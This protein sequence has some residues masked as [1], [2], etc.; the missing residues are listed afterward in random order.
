MKRVF[1]MMSL[2]FFSVFCTLSTA[3]AEMVLGGSEKVGIGTASPQRLLH[4][5]G[6][7][8]RILIEDNWTSNPEINF[9][10]QSGAYGNDWAIYKHYNSGDLRFYNAG[11][12]VT[13]EYDSGWVGIGVDNPKATL[14]VNG[15]VLLKDISPYYEFFA[16]YSGI[17]SNAGQLYSVDG[18]GNTTQISP[19]DAE[20]G[21]W[22]F[23]SKNVK[24]GKVFRVNMEK[25]V[26]EVEKLTGKK[27]VE[28]WVEK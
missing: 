5:Y 10:T 11:D 12:K 24:T 18:A 19:H 13:F 15:T 22:I 21:E 20:T 27:F 23:Y 3:G 16:G 14:T 4:L 26:R 2:V 25:L 7:N 1:L 6:N 9:K 17:F 8:P 28:E